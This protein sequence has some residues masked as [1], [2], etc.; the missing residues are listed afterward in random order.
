MSGP[1]SPDLNTLDYQVWANA[2]KLTVEAKII[3][4]VKNALQTSVQLI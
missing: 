2:A 4:Q 1:N 3:F